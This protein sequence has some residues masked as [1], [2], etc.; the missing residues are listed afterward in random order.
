MALTIQFFE[1][2]IVNMGKGNI[3]MSSDVFKIMLVNNYSFAA[4]HEDLSEASGF[5]I[6]EA[7]GYLADGGSVGNITWAW[8]ETTSRVE[9]KG[10]NVMWSAGGGD[11]GPSTGAILYSSTSGDNKMVCYIDFAGSETASIGTDFIITWSVDG[12]LIVS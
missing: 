1:Q 2:F 11:I 5:E 6:N 12:I 7:N 9:F 4:E 3:D 10:D 8:N